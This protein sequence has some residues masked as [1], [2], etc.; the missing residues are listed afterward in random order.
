MRTDHPGEPHPQRASRRPAD[1]DAASAQQA[2][3]SLEDIAREDYGLDRLRPGQVEAMRALST[4]RDVLAVMPTGYG[5]SAIYQVVGSQLP[6]PTVV[7]SPL[8]AL[9]SDQVAGIEEA[10]DAPEAVAV[11]SAQ[12]AAEN[13]DAWRAITGED[14][15]FLFLLPEQHASERVLQRV[16]DLRPS[17]FVVDEAH[18]VSSWGHDFRP[19]YLTLADAVERL[20]HPRVVALTATAAPPIRAEILERLG[21]RDPVLVAGGFDRPN[22]FLDVRR[23]TS[24]EAL[25]R[26]VLEDVA[27]L[28]GGSGTGL[29]YVA[30]RRD[31]ETYAAALTQRDIRAV[32][33][34]AGLTGDQRESAQHA[35]DTG[36][37][38]V[39]VATSAFGMGIDKPDVR[40]VVHA[41]PPGSLDSYYQEIGRAGRDGDPA[42]VVL[43]FRPE[44][45]ALRRFF[46]SMTAPAEDLV[47]ALD[48]MGDGSASMSALRAAAGLSPR[49]ATAVVNLLV[50][51][52][53]A[54]RRGRRLVRLRGVSAAEAAE[55]ATAHVEARERVERS[56]VE[57]MRGYAETTGCRREFLL[58]YFGEAYDPPCGTCD[59]CLTG[60]VSEPASATGPGDF[61]PQESVVHDTFGTGTVMSVE[62]D[63]VTVFFPDHGYR[64]L[65]REH[66]VRQGLLERARAD[67]GGSLGP[68]S[69]C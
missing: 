44:D 17:L 64:T 30:R 31:A 35:F 1:R 46:S 41:A 40:F 36:S 28:A 9:Q 24:A 51:V 19:A 20:G 48:A 21:M 66:V 59:N 55:R 37:A 32:A 16:A 69:G 3:R 57:M 8:I 45:L 38:E 26:A 10:P 65:A 63:R 49:R 53:A 34:H 54:E 6:G 47:A 68:P 33:Y 39:V 50:E 43:H 58:G 12:S 15:E 2:R 56:R 14:A 4:G 25:R 22:L 27:E 18:C 29:V 23:E 5:K 60:Q 13:D 42:T 7:V 52:G 62:D 67:D 61:R 11:N